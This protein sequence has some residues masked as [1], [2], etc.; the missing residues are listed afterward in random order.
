M[1]IT[2][3]SELP[4]LKASVIKQMQSKN[5]I[6][7]WRRSVIN[8]IPSKKGFIPAL[9]EVAVDCNTQNIDTYTSAAQVYL[10]SSGKRNGIMLEAER[11]IYE[12]QKQFGDKM[13]TLYKILTI[14]DTNPKVMK[15][16]RE[17]KK[18]YG[19]KSLYLN[20][21]LDFA[22]SCLQVAKIFK[23]KGYTLPDEIIASDFFIDEDDSC[24]SMALEGKKKT[25][26]INPE[27]MH[28]GLDW[29]CSVRSPLHTIVHECVHCL[30]PLLTCFNMKKIPA[31]YNDT[32]ANLSFYA[33]ENSAH[34]I[35]AELLT[36][37]I[38]KGLN[39]DEEELLKYLSI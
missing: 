17:L 37:K 15:I 35:H 16:K 33:R 3:N 7:N 25:I 18:E 29:M 10:N 24:M 26:L 4:V 31:K 19:I 5:C 27:C 23:E 34:E 38:L 12:L 8:A 2:L 13:A 28:D 11:A 1:T 21:N 22:E 14:K 9:R 36:K 30:Q 6:T 32:I 20:N 39:P